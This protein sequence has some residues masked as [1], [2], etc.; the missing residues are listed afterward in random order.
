MASAHRGLSDAFRPSATILDFP[1]RGARR[2]L[3]G[4][5]RAVG[6]VMFALA[7]AAAVAVAAIAVGPRLLPYQALPVL[8][9]S[10]EPTI[11][12][13]SLAVMLPVRGDD[14]VV[15]DIITFHHPQDP[16][17]YVTH[18]VIAID[19]TAGRRILETK[20]DA[21]ALADPWRVTASGTGWRYALALP[22]VGALVVAF[23]ASPLRAALFALPLLALASMALYRIWRPQPR[24][25]EARARAA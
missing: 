22:A 24:D 1:R 11:P 2:S 19:E 16:R 18:R 6:D 12:T 13:G 25:V 10:M 4:V 5:T 15:G 20:G 17:S 9:G 14:L 8:T 7:A 3:L 23:G 21:N